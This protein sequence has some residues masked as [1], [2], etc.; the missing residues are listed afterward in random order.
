LISALLTD[1]RN[2]QP[3][4]HPDQRVKELLE[5]GV[6]RFNCPEFIANDPIAVP[7][8]F[9]LKQ[10]IEISGFFAAILAWGQRPTI[11]RKAKELMQLFDNAPYQWISGHQEADLK[12]LLHFKHR[13]FQPTDLLYFV[14][15]FREFYSEH[16][17]LE[18]AFVGQLTEPQDQSSRLSRFYNTLFDS[19]HCPDRSRKHVSTP[20]RQSACKRINMY[21]RWMVR[22]DNR[23]VDFGLWQIIKPS[24]LICP[25]DLHVDRVGKMLGLIT[26]P[27]TDWS[28]AEELTQNLRLYDAS[29]PVKY[30]FALFGLGIED[31]IGKS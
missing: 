27:K 4:Q 13:T 18:E 22:K 10:D 21:L 24:E 30:D 8:Q 25:I 31:G 9:S 20:A 14:H 26:R 5:Y 15:R 7:H 29:D 12:Q 1:I 19:P 3:R 17:S 23:G 11:L 6:D 16:K 2:N 28:T